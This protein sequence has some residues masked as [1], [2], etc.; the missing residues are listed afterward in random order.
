MIAAIHFVSRLVRRVLPALALVALCGAGPGMAQGLP[1]HFDPNMRQANQALPNL[2]A[3][4]FLTTSD[5]PPFNFR[6]SEGALVGYNVDLAE[7]ICDEL[8]TVCTLQVWPWDQAADALADNQG[9]A[10]IGGLALDDQSAMRFDFSQ[11]YLRF[12]ARFVVQD[13]ETGR[14]RTAG[15]RGPEAGGAGRIE[16]CR[17]RASLPAGGQADRPPPL[18]SPR[19]I[20]SAAASPTPFSAMHCARVSGSLRMGRA[21]ALPAAPISGPTISAKVLPSPWPKDGA[22]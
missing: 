12:P 15:A 8:K 20:S 4:R 1:R 7:A 3:L 17:F 2:P 18:N 9:D 13:G 5:F 11:V 16:P 6:D 22:R 10:L 21:A 19:S 14:F